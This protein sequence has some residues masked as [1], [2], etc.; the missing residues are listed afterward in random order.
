MRE[1]EGLKTVKVVQ[2]TG[3]KQNGTMSARRRLQVWQ[4]AN[5]RKPTQRQ[6]PKRVCGGPSET[7]PQLRMS[8]ALGAVHKVQI[9][10]SNI[11]SNAVILCKCSA[12]HRTHR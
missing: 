2:K 4:V 1:K 8:D 7:G 12:I 9:T 5:G 10:S 6:V 3:C 11:I